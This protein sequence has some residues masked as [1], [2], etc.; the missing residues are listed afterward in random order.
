MTGETAGRAVRDEHD[1]LRRELDERVRV[2][3]ERGT[4]DDLTALLA[5]LQGDLLSHA[6]AEQRH[7]YPVVDE[8]VRAHGRA[9]ATMDIDHEA[10]ELRVTRIAAA[11]ARLIAASERQTRMDAKSELREELL[12]LDTLLRVHLDKEERVYLPL[13]E[14]HL[15][16]A[17]QAS[18]AARMH[19]GE[20]VADPS[21]TT[22]DV[23]AIPQR[24]RHPRIFG[25]FDALPVGA[26][27]VIVSD[28]DPRH[29]SYE[30]GQKRP[31]TFTW[32]YVER[33][34]LWRVRVTRRHL[35]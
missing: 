30:L 17:E 28:H 33:G 5:L 7:L 9:T 8:I 4:R 10:I 14:A 27:L 13:L 34:P 22:I 19:Q 11:V 24:E 1:E 26:S 2:A 29:L 3:L 20:P 12:R 25:S 6:R 15:P 23:R 35:G 21:G 16:A 32:E 18:V 31:G